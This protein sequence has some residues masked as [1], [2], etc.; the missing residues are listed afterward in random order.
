MTELAAFPVKPVVE[1]AA[2]QI[3]GCIHP[4]TGN[5]TNSDARTGISNTVGED[6]TFLDIGAGLPED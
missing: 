2:P 4:L 3:I 1:N 6:F 5:Y